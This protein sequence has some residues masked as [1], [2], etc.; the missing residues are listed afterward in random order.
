[1][2]FTLSVSS[3]ILL[4]FTG[5]VAGFVDSI[6]GGGGLISLPVLLSVGIPPQLALGTNKLQGSFGSM[7]AAITF[8][9]KG[10]VRLD[11]NIH[12]IVFTFMGAVLG[13]WS[14]QQ[15]DAGFI[16]HIIPVLLLFVF[17]YTLFARDLGARSSHPK[18]AEPLF[19]TL[20]G[21]GLG[22]YDGFFGPG[23]GSFWTGGLL[24]LMGMDMTKAAGTTRIMNFTSNIVALSLFIIG[25]N[26]LYSAGL[27]MAAGQIIGARAGSGMAIKRGASFIRPIFLTMVFLTIVRL[28]IVNYF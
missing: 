23:T 22:F 16:R 17:F 12:G 26:V 21:L 14:I 8:I 25:K 4:F 2:E 28:M 10:T 20:F 19:F 18:M 5:L 7:T 11:E 6:A 9:R 13:A 24:I 3:L 15:I 27:C 1:M